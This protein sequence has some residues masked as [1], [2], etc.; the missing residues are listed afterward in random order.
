MTD[1]TDPLHDK[2]KHPHRPDHPDF[3]RL[4]EILLQL[5]AYGSE[6]RVRTAQYVSKRQKDPVTS[7]FEHTI[8]PDTLVYVATQRAMLA[9]GRIGD[10]P[11]EQSV[12]AAWIDGFMIGVRYQERGG[13]RDK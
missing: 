3:W 6:P 10:L 11:M 2:S 1:S 9:R 5:D 7:L 8:D 13:H 4:S 12:R